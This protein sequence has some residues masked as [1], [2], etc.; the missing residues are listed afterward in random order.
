MTRRPV[1]VLKHEAGHMVVANV[2]GFQTDRLV[3]KHSHARAEL[4]ID[5]TLSD[6]AAVAGFIRRRVPILYAGALAESL[7]GEKVDTDKAFKLVRGPEAADDYSKA[8]ELFRVLAGIERGESEYQLVLDR[9]DRSLEQGC[10]VSSEVCT[11]N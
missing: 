2:L 8:R 5:L 6:T 10:F 9:L 1:D 11:A 3:Y 7:N 4:A